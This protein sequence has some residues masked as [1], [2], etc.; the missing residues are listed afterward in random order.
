[1][2]FNTDFVKY[3]IRFIYFPVFIE[4]FFYVF[5]P[6]FIDTTIIRINFLLFLQ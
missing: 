4:V 2:H 1:M 6:I 3:V 5:H